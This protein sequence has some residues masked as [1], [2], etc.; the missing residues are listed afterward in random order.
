MNFFH[1]GLAKERAWEE[2]LKVTVSL[3]KVALARTSPPSKW[4]GDFSEFKTLA[5]IEVPK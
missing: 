1:T 5:M 2:T 4:N 3:L